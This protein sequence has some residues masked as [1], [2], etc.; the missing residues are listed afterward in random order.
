R[1]RRWSPHPTPAP[2]AARGEP[3][4]S[5]RGVTAYASQGPVSNRRL[6]W[7]RLLAITSPAGFEV[8]AVLHLSTFTPLP[9]VYAA[10][11]AMVLFAVAFALLAAMIARL[12]HAG[13]TVRGESRVRMVAWR[14][15]LAYIPE[16]PRRAAVAVIAYVLMN[17]TLCLLLADES[18]ARGG[19]L[20][21]RPPR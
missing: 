16:G 15:L 10:A 21:R 6:N 20:A 11:I 4:E 1:S 13:A 17:L 8:G 3:R 7:G 18:V 2:G 19:V 5:G 12:R 9:P 14:T